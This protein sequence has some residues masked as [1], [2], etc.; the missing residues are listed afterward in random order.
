MVFYVT[1]ILKLKNTYI[2]NSDTD[3]VKGIHNFLNWS[4]WLKTGLS[5]GL[6]RLLILFD[7]FLNSFVVSHVDSSDEDTSKS[8]PE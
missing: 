7:T 8:S 3:F 5:N 1:A 2:G 4:L 6:F